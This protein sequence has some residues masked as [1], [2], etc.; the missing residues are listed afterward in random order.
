MA[1]PHVALPLGG[2]VYGVE[3]GGKRLVVVAVFYRLHSVGKY[4]RH[5]AAESRCWMRPDGLAQVGGAV[6]RRGGVDGW[7]CRVVALIS[8]EDG[9]AKDGGDD[10]C[11]VYD[12]ARCGSAGPF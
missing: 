5:G 3:A 1:A 10:G 2:I 8:H 4:R 11:S 12:G 6:W 9:S 7:P